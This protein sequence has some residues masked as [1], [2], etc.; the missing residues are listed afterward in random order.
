MCVCIKT[1][2]ERQNCKSRSRNSLPSIFQPNISISLPTQLTFGPTSHHSRFLWDPPVF[3]FFFAAPFV[4]NPSQR[5]R[6]DRMAVGAHPDDSWASIDNGRMSLLL[7]LVGMPFLG[8]RRDSRDE[9]GVSRDPATFYFE[10][11]PS[12]FSPP[13]PGCPVK[14]DVCALPTETKT[15]PNFPAFCLL[16]TRAVSDRNFHVEMQSNHFR[17]PSTKMSTLHVL[18]LFCFFPLVLLSLVDN[19]TQSRAD[20]SFR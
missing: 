11:L 13:N 1:G 14:S 3:S 2:S 4:F 6:W 16:T 19:R 10:Y 12:I 7:P 15:N 18:L 20:K 9:R 5:I 17:C 8:I